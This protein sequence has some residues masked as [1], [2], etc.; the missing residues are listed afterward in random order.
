LFEQFSIPVCEELGVHDGNLEFRAYVS[1]NETLM[2]LDST[3]M[4]QRNGRL[5][6]SSFYH[7]IYFIVDAMVEIDLT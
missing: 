3:E 5:K 4:L 2:R 1:E 7:E 6:P